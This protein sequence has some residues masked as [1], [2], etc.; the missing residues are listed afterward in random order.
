MAALMN[1]I[2]MSDATYCLYA[3]ECC[4]TIWMYLLALGYLNSSIDCKGG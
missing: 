2:N 1:C 4:M 3:G